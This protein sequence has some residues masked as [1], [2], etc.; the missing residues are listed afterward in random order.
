M[1]HCAEYEGNAVIV[2]ENVVVGWNVLV[3]VLVGKMVGESKVTPTSV[4]GVVTITVGTA[5]TVGVDA[6]GVSGI[7]IVG[8]WS[9]AAII[10][11]QQLMI[12]SASIIFILRA[13][14]SVFPTALQ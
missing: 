2:G 7:C 4:V 12:T 9:S 13:T 8:N 14:P 5:T 3:L 11:Q 10:G 6:V 1:L